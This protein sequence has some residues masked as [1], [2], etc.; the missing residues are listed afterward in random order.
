MQRAVILSLVVG[1]LV[2][3]GCT[4]RDQ[5][6][7]PCLDGTRSIVV[8]PAHS[9]ATWPADL[10]IENGSTIDARATAFEDSIANDTGHRVSVKI[11]TYDSQEE[12][13]CLL[14]GT[15]FTDPAALHPELT[16]WD[17]WHRATAVTVEKPDF[18]LV[19]TRLY[20]H[21]DGI[22]FAYEAE[23]WRVTGVRV[24]A[25]GGGGAGYIHDDCIENDN[26]H[27][28]VVADSK[29]DGCM[30][31][32]SAMAGQTSTRDGSHNT[33]EVV[34][35]LVRLRPYLNSFD[36]E[37]YGF[38]NTGGF[39]K[40]G[41][42]VGA[43][44]APPR[45]V[46]RSSIFRADQP[47]AYGGNANGILGLPPGTVCEDVALVGTATWPADELESWT[48]QCSGLHLASDAEWDQAVAAWDEAHPE[49]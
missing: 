9:T 30:V 26:M 6:A 33:V 10:L 41:N 25:P 14:G 18:H 7:G 5:A 20:N 31:F 39:F 48:S 11:A 38:G 3:T 24:D 34:G 27:A 44:G 16:P 40:W 29:L 43:F 32:M 35:T 28:G 36:P 37:R 8:P 12:D 2:A 49:L 23:R 1:A 46:I 15:A 17:T 42:G 45:L 22:A 4:P 19:G 47:G 21:G 13:L